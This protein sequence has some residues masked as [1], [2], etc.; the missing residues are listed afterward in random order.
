MFRR[1]MRGGGTWLVV[2]MALFVCHVMVWGI[3]PVGAVF[4]PVD[5]AELKT[6]VD[7]CVGV[8]YSYFPL[9]C[10]SSCLGL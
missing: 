3:V 2:E 7:S 5:R 4:A 1:R 9:C 6:A 10:S 8:S